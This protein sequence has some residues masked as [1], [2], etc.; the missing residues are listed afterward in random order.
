VTCPP[1]IPIGKEVQQK[2]SLIESVRNEI[3]GM[4]RFLIPDIN[5]F[6]YR[7]LAKAVVIHSCNPTPSVKTGLFLCKF[8]RHIDLKIE[9]VKNKAS[10]RMTGNL[11]AVTSA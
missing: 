1:D 6:E 10:Y 3:K 8:H 7:K 4:N 2:Q 9:Q 5:K 11:P